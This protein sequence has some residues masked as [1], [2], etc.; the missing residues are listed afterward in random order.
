MNNT[1]IF[2]IIFFLLGMYI[3]YTD[4]IEGFAVDTAT[5]DA[6]KKAVN[7][8]YLT[9]VDAI[10]NL[11]EVAT[12]LQKDGLTL[13][14]DFTVRGKINVNN[15]AILKKSLTVDG[16][17]S[18]KNTLTVDGATILKGVNINGDTNINGNTNINGITTIKGA[19][20]IFNIEGSAVTGIGSNGYMQ[21]FPRTQAQGR[22]GYIG[23]S[24][25]ESTNLELRNEDNGSVIIS[26]INKTDA[27]TIDKDGIIKTNDTILR[28]MSGIPNDIN[29]NITGDN[30]GA[31][32]WQF[33]KFNNNSSDKSG[34]GAYST[35]EILN[36]GRINIF[37]CYHDWIPDIKQSQCS[38]KYYF[39]IDLAKL[40]KKLPDATSTSTTYFVR[41]ELDD[42]IQMNIN[43]Q[44]I[45]RYCCAGA[46]NKSHV[47]MVQINGDKIYG[48]F[49]WYNWDKASKLGL[50][51]EQF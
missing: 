45:T 26:T 24:G 23:F 50:R 40:K 5:N 9:D 39:Y 29:L 17:T 47:D 27:L 6:I 11:S 21:F 4:Y 2:I 33:R 22:K 46:D 10:R 51:I 44:S 34:I 32:Y 19:G 48:S 14:G 36:G 31:T 49:T 42:Y 12:K 3:Y 1:L 13:P 35:A 18:L 30:I 37:I 16:A 25:N 8:I 41:T 28:M 43:G 38:L 15:N 7:D 20:G